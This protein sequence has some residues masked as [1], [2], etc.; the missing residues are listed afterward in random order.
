MPR[1]TPK[2]LP[3]SLLAVAV[4]AALPA[5]GAPP[6]RPAPAARPKAPVIVVGWDGGDWYL[7]DELIRR[8]QAPNLARLV[9]QGRSWTLESFNPMISPLVWT[10][11]ATGRS[12]VVHGVTDFQELDPVSRVRL[13]VSGSA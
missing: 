6:A 4:L 11:I 9:A 12:P 10:T 8:G 1:K 3:A 2:T 5:A 7:L 13:P